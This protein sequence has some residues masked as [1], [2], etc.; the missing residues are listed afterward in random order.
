MSDIAY[1]AKDLKEVLK[2]VPDDLPLVGYNGGDKE[3]LN[4]IIVYVQGGKDDKD[5]PNLPPRLVIS[6]ED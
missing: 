3:I 6:V 1:T 4:G 2:N 5:L